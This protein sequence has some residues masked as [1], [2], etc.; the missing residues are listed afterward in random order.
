MWDP[1][2]SRAPD[3]G[4]RGRAGRQ[5]RAPGGGGSGSADLTWLAPQ[6]QSSPSSTRPLPQRARGT[7]SLE[8]GALERHAPPPLRKKARSWRRLQA[9]NTRGNGRLR[10]GKGVGRAGT[11]TLGPPLLSDLLPQP[12]GARTP[13]KRPAA[14]IL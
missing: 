7:R 1:V 3:L 6:S 10:A 12:L 11:A 13:P 2:R 14:R 8:S 5:P 4:G 9:L